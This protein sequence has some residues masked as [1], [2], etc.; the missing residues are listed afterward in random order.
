MLLPCGF[1][2][3]S[4]EAEVT[5]HKQ[6]RNAVQ[7][8][9]SLACEEL[10]SDPCESEEEEAF[11]Y[12]EVPDTTYPSITIVHEI[13]RARP[14]P[15][16]VNPEQSNLRPEAE[17]FQ[18]AEPSEDGL[19]EDELSTDLGEKKEKTSLVVEVDDVLESV[20]ETEHRVEQEFVGEENPDESS[21]NELEDSRVDD[22]CER[23]EV[24]RSTRH[25]LGPDRLTYQTLGNPLT[26]VMQ[27]LLKG[28]DQ[29]FTKALDLNPVIKSTPLEIGHLT[30]V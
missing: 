17:V 11:D 26:L 13:P 6:K 15:S 4:I 20:P 12:S 5:Q 24:R 1:L 18:P 29:A 14:R 30:T 28:L 27:S 19:K 2:A 21:E 7:P 22:V 3:P 8:V 25:R 9:Q 23:E 16:S 10:L